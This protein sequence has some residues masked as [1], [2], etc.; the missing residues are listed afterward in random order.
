MKVAKSVFLKILWLLLRSPLSNVDLELE[1]WQQL[2][3]RGGAYFFRIVLRKSSTEETY[4]L[5]FVKLS[6]IL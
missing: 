4:L 1:S 3:G 6:L 2:M 5:I